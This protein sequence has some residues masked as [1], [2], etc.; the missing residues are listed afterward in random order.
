MALTAGGLLRRRKAVRG[1]PGLPRTAGLLAAAAALL[2]LLSIQAPSG[3]G[4]HP[5]SILPPGYPD[6]SAT[7]DVLPGFKTPP[8]GYGEVPFYWWL[9]DTLTHERILWQMDQL[10]GHG[11]MGLQ[12]NYA[13]SDS[14]G[15]LWGLTY[16]SRPALFSDEWWKLFGW[17]LAQAKQRGMSVSISDY[18]L[19]HAG[20]GWYVDEMLGEHPEVAG[21]RLVGDT[22]ICDP[23]QEARRKV[24][25][26]LLSARA[27]LLDRGV[28]APGPA[29]DLMAAVRSGELRWKPGAGAW[30]I[31]LVRLEHVPTSIDPMHALSGKL[32]V[33]KFY[34]RFEDHFPGEA[35][36]GLNFFFSDE[37]DLGIRGWLWNDDFAAEFARR[38][39][40]DIRP[41]LPALF[42]DIGPRT[43]KVRLDYSDVMVAL[44]EEC[45]FRVIYDWHASRGMLFGCDHGGRGLDVTEF[46]DYFRA[47]RWVSGPGCDQPMLQRNVIKNKVASSIA[48][49]YRRPRTWLEGFHS[50]G[51]GTSSAQIADAIFTNFA[52]GQNLLS[53][54]GLYYST[55]GSWWEW[56][57]PDNHWRQPYWAHMGGLLRCTERL[58]YLLSQGYHRCDVAILYPVAPVEAGMGGDSAVATAFETGRNLSAAGI[59]FDFMDFESL[60]RAAVVGNELR[61]SGERYRVLV[62]PAMTAIRHSSVKKALAFAGAG[63]T[64]IAVGAL[65]VASDR[66]G[67]QD[68]ELLRM[69]HELF[70]AKAAQGIHVAD[71]VGSVAAVDAAV[72][73]DV[74]VRSSGPAPLVLH[75]RIGEREIYY[76]YGGEQ[77]AECRLRAA[78]RVELWDPWT[79]AV[80]PLP[81]LSSGHGG[82]VLHLPLGRQEPQILVVRPG[83]SV[84]ERRSR[85]GRPQTDTVR[86]DG[87]WEFSLKPTLDN[88][89]GDYRLPGNDGMI[90]AE[91]S[92][93][94]YRE[95]PA[96]A[97]FWRLPA[98]ADSDWAQV[99]PSYGPQFWELGPLPADSNA[100]KLE[101]VLVAADAVDPAR[102]VRVGRR[103]YRWAPY[104]FSWRW[105]V[106]GDPG[107]QGYHGLKGLVHDDLIEVGR[108]LRDWPGVP[109][110]RY[111][112]D[113][114]RSRCY[115]WSTVFADSAYRAWLL[116]GGILPSA[117]WV[118]HRLT[119]GSGAFADLRRG[120]N[121][122]LLRYDTVG[123]GY[124]VLASG[125]VKP[126]G[127]PL[128]S[129]WYG[130]TGVLP[131]DPRADA[132]LHPGWYRFQAPPGLRALRLKIRGNVRLWA[133]GAR[134]ATTRSP[135]V[136]RTPGAGEAVIAALQSPLARWSTITM[137]VEME[138]GFSGGGAIAGPVGFECSGGLILTGDL[139]ST[140]ALAGYSGGM[141]YRTTVALPDPPG[142]VELDLGEVVSSAEV[143]VN[144]TPAGVRTAP[145]WR[146]NITR[147]VR[148]GEN[149]ITITVFNTLGNH[150]RATPSAY[151]GSTRSGLIGPVR[152]VHTP[153]S[154]PPDGRERAPRLPPEGG[155]H[156]DF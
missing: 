151:V 2:L 79:G 112:R 33:R 55:H 99:I 59:D 70:N 95:A 97:E 149:V 39:K 143:A 130:S 123:R 58:S 27:Y 65:P 91:A 19:G 136:S 127:L 28:A 125:P 53:L 63:G 122:V 38:K 52:M 83:R 154:G 135:G 44:S 93:I 150:Y 85:E 109:A 24:A 84:P 16:K 114:A 25:G 100:G 20:Q 46:G 87:E 12:V 144:G 121:A 48:H 69:V 1:I 14:G 7:L 37:L 67:R 62:L 43:P 22:L 107:H 96:S 6:R 57:P 132:G 34:Q 116:R 141:V 137:S 61:V 75:R 105:G 81:V 30:K 47:Q 71:P 3:D 146:F 29:R 4:K 148:P 89:W 101:A 108:P 5:R 36:R 10:A 86:I 49:L 120:A 23:G 98:G 73:R 74:V 153:A 11:V 102:P 113:T 68:P 51:W 77:G 8:P 119:G 147:E 32:F 76:L 72:P 142:E 145:P 41:E 92:V 82:T 54:H 124:C 64:V 155:E 138:R 129:R 60:A 152:I 139:G 40:Y 15:L 45:F 17:F 26:T 111:E 50:S 9:G 106:K 90:G 117:V 156:A 128:A 66:S 94:R 103:E 134:L 115:F 31:V 80:S 140:E 104:E 126:G 110:P 21:S 88:R 133:D 56:A 118:D 131:F 13:H 18:T 78:G 42:T 35:G